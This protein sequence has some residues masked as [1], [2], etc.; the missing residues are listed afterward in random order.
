M[1]S[2]FQD[3]RDKMTQAHK[4]AIETSAALLRQE[5]QLEA[6]RRLQE[7]VG[8]LER[9]GAESECR[10]QLEVAILKAFIA[11]AQQRQDLAVG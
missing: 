4:V 10:W 2:A 3:E 8:R 5:L 1:M 9:E 6:D 11:D 7:E